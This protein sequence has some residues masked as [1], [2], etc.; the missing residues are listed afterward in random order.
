M[1][2]NNNHIIL[3]EELMRLVVFSI[4]K[5]ISEDFPQYRHNNKL[6]TDNG[7]SFMKSNYINDNLR[8]NVVSNSI[9]LVPFSRGGWKGRVL[10]DLDNKITYSI[11]RKQTL[12]FAINR[13][14]TVPYYLQSILFVENGGFSRNSEPLFD[15]GLYDN[16]LPFSD[17]ELIDDYNSIFKN[18]LSEAEKYRHYVITYDILQNEVSDI[19]LIFFDKNFE[20]IESRSLKEYLKPDFASLTN[21]LNNDVCS[22]HVADKVE[23][24]IKIRPSVKPLLRASENEA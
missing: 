8:K 18:Q 2:S 17:D 4:S 14:R 12:D 10:V 7:V 23:N 11:I 16:Y 21:M 5:A 24:L 3:N 6:E 1:D 20:I 13:K 15:Y 22:V 19:K 9:I